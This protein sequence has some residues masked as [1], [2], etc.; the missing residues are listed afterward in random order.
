MKVIIAIF[1]I[2]G[3]IF[4]GWRIY[5][6]WLE[7][8]EQNKSK[9]QQSA[10]SQVPGDQLPGLPPTL[11]SILQVSQSK[12][13]T[14]LQ[15]FLVQY[16]HTISDPRLASIELDFVVLVAQKDP[17]EAKRVYAKVKSR[18]PATSPVYVRMK[19]LEKTY[20]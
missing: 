9:E 1:L 10:Q 11:E 18:T 8:D 13:A 15:Q 17:S 3:A 19:Q 6:Y 14:G 7:V 2:V 4:G 12:G 16:G 5:T 20:E